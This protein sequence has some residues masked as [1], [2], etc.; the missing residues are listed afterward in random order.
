VAS[1]RVIA[2][3]TSPGHAHHLADHDVAAPG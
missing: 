3:Q 2:P 1:R